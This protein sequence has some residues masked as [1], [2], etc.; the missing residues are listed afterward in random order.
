MP[1]YRCWTQGAVEC[2][3]RG[4][5]CEG[6]ETFELIGKKCQMKKAVIQLVA[7]C[8]K[9]SDD[10]EI[11]ND[12]N[13]IID[14]VKSKLSPVSSISVLQKQLPDKYLPNSA[15]LTNLPNSKKKGMKFMF[16]EDLNLRYGNSLV[17]MINAIKQ[18]YESYEDLAKYTGKDSHLLSVNFSDFHKY[19]VKHNF[20]KEN[21]DKTKKQAV[22]DFIQSRLIDKEYTEEVK[23][24]RSN[25]AKQDE[26][27]AATQ[28]DKPINDNSL[29][30]SD[31]PSELEELRNENETLRKRIEELE[32]QPKQVVDFGAVKAKIISKIDELNEKLKAIELLETTSFDV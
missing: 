17:P 9:P 7:S 1:K 25:A 11:P 4:C 29:I 22:I 31:M 21:S 23:L 28:G 30:P 27:K 19:L 18:G 32:N 26:R 20:V 2:Y 15:N 16:D 13:K 12:F 5:V 3:S 8:G 14:D 6:C 10:W 24:L